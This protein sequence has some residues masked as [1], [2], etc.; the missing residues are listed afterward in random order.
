MRRIYYLHFLFT[1]VAGAVLSGC[2]SYAPAPR[3]PAAV[4]DEQASA[5]LDEAAVRDEITRLEPGAEWDGR[6]LDRLSLLAAALTTNPEIAHARASANAA[7]AAARAA[8]VMQGPTLLL[9]TEYAFNAP[10]ASPW[11]LGV[12]G[13]ILL[14]TGVRRESR[15]NLAE[16]GAR[17]ALFDYTDTAWSVRLRIRTTLAQLL[18]ARKE[19]EAATRLAELRGR[20]LTAMEHRLSAGAAA[21]T[22]VELARAQLATDR[23]RLA[24][25]QARSTAAQLQLAAAVGVPAATLDE[26]A[27]NWPE[28]AA[29]TTWT[30]PLPPTCLDAALLA[31]PDISRASLAYD[32]AEAAL[33][34][35]VASQYPQLHLGPAYAWERGLKKLPFVLSLSLPPL[36]LNHA[37]IAAAEARR[38]EA[39][40]ALEAVVAAAGTAV[41]LAQQDYEAAWIQLL[42]SRQQRQIADRLSMQAETAIGAGAI[43]R[44][45]WNT[46]Q[47]GRMVAALDELTAVQNVRSAEAALENALRRPLDGPELAITTAQIPSEDPTCR[48]PLSTP[49]PLHP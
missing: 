4:L 36:D 29:P 49:P 17:I 14:D 46:A 30:G 23:R 20:Q 8:H 5:R 21:H 19:V 28:I 10:E 7:A 39:G 13:D 25:A 47:S 11:Q 40:Y 43:D 6:R 37:A 16:L 3:T 44:F 38:L 2:V 24:D 34:S 27:L 12:G 41:E 31:R 1:L 32:Q 45:E 26:S 33:K 18:L 48:L 9:T 22:D 35:A 42:Q 15:I